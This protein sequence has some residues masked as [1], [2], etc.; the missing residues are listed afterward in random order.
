MSR[1][2]GQAEVLLLPRSFTGTPGSTLQEGLHACEMLS[3]LFVVATDLGNSSVT[4]TAPIV[5]K[6]A[7]KVGDL[8]RTLKDLWLLDACSCL[9]A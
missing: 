2:H 1:D 4:R 3:Q 8:Q 6:Q 9:G 5:R 7:Y